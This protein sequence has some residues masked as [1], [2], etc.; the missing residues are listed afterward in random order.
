[1]EF[2]NREK[3]LEQLEEYY[4]LSFK[5]QISSVI[6]GLRRVGKTTLVKEF[7]K[8]KKAIYF[9]VY[10]NKT[11][12]ELLKEFSR[13]L[14]EK[15][16]ITELEKIDSWNIF[17]NVLFGRCKNYIIIFD[18]FQN[19]YSVEKSVYSIIQKNFDENISAHLYILFLGSLIGLFKRIF[20]DKKQPLYGRI[21]SK[22]NLNPF[23]LKNSLFALESL[24]YSN[25]E[26]MI[27]I[28]GIFGGFPKY[29]AD[30]EKFNLINK[31][32]LEIINYLFVQENSPLENEV[33][34]ILKQEFGR[35]SSLYY[36]IL[37]AI[38]SGKTKLNEIA[39]FTG[40]KES[41]I[42]RH[43]I[44]L[45][46]RF[47]LIKSLK[48]LNNKKSSRYLITHP[49]I[50]FWFR[51]IYDKFSKYNLGNS[52]EI[53]SNINQNFNSFFG[54]RF[55]EICKDVLIE[56]NKEN[57]L[58]FK[59]EYLSNWWGFSRIGGERKEIE[60]D[61]IGKNDKLKE[62][63]FA[64]CKWKEKVNSMEIV[65]ELNEKSEHVKWNNGKRR[66]YFVIFAKS[67]SKKISKF[68]NKEVY[69]LDLKDI[70]RI[71]LKNKRRIIKK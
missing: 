11:S 39:N 65:N 32:C 51:F 50:A 38:A 68:K 13:E 61:L 7:I 66:E 41:S 20:E 1:M 30:L 43:L 58:S 64:E 9:F 26:E 8:N 45:E 4:N 52:K 36:S 33:L 22:I 57:K 44:E 56:L 18:E 48:P 70:K 21:S 47:G 24:N 25:F 67:F 34:D 3:E 6:S 16:V 28:Y 59:I 19:F 63:L 46:E 71:M 17:F 29:Y 37:N 69:C 23:T 15:Q 55:E 53:L 2:I 42:T 31:N 49:L 12:A 27:K 10:E 35:R 54:R 40:T 62:I 5:S 60:I 14:K